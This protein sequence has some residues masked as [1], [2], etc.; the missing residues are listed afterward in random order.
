M[1]ICYTG[2]YALTSFAGGAVADVVGH[3]RVFRVGVALTAVALLPAASRR[4][5]A[6][7]SRRA[8]CRA[9]RAASSTAPRPAS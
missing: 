7:C 5:S 4:A 6:G 3:V 1:I 9:W 2:V 8:S